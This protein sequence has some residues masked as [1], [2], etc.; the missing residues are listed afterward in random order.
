MA[1]DY[2]SLSGSWAS[3]DDVGA[4]K[5]QQPLVINEMPGEIFLHHFWLVTSWPKDEKNAEELVSHYRERG[6]A[7]GI[8]GELMDG[9]EPTLSSNKRPKSHYK[10]RILPKKVEKNLTFAINEVRLILSA[11][12]Y[13][14]AHAVRCAAQEVMQVGMRI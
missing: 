14:L 10:G 9:I 2:A 6:S 4:E 12:A 3:L 13:N 8:F 1:K 5:R 11:L 7:E